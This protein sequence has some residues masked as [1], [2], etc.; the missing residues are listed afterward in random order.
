MARAGG[1]AGARA[2]RDP[3]APS[4][5]PKPAAAGA[6]ARAWPDD[7]ARAFAVEFAAR[8]PQ[9]RRRPRPGRRG[10]SV[11]A[12]CLRRT[13][14]TRWRHGSTAHGP[15]QTIGAVA[16]AEVERLDRE[17]AL[18]TVA[19]SVT[20][21]ASRLV[22]LT[23]P[24]ARDARRR[25]GRLRPSRARAR[26]R[27]AATVRHADAEPLTGAERD[28]IYDVLSRYFLRPTWPATRGALAYLVPPGTRIA[29]TAGAF[30]LVELASVGALG[31]P[32]PRRAAR[33]G[34]GRGAR[35]RCRV[36]CWRCATA[37]GWCAVTAGTSPSSTVPEARDEPARA[38]RTRFSPRRAAAGD[39]AAF[40]ELARRY[41]PLILAVTRDRAGRARGRGR[42]PGGADRAVCT[43][44]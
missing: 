28:A 35:R 11:G 16:V 25:P 30:E 21:E 23:V 5:R 31:P 1:R 44:A 41:R 15:R 4:R 40:A 33:A 42:A 39:G 3:R 32:A 9:A 27:R 18:V 37:C 36:R 8:L 22:R 24:V 17:H 13:P 2:G 14:R 34:H 7:A 38:Y 10:R 6:A 43:R 19:A 20:G 26:R 29:A 12:V